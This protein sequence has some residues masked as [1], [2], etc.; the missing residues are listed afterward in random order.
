[1][2]CTWS[3]GLN[4]VTVTKAI[5]TRELQAMFGESGPDIVSC[6]SFK[7]VAQKQITCVSYALSCGNS[8]FWFQF[9]FLGRAFRRQDVTQIPYTAE[10]TEVCFQHIKAEPVTQLEMMLYIQCTIPSFLKKRCCCTLC[11]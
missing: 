2:S 9:C 11:R 7:H 1:M 8:E 5:F 6:C 10:I 4:I 3:L